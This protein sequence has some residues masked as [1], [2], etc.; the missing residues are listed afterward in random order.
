MTPTPSTTP[1]GTTPAGTT[2]AA[3]GRIHGPWILALALILVSLGWMIAEPA[4]LAGWLAASAF[5]S[6]LPL[7]ALVLVMMIRIIPG[8][9]RRELSGPGEAMMLLLPLMMLAAL[10]LLI[11]PG[12]VYPWVSGPERTGFRTLYLTP[13]F[14]ALRTVIF[15]AVVAGFAALLLLARRRP[16]AIPAGGLILVTLLHTM[17]AVD[18]LMSL[19]PGFHSSGF[20][21][22]VL[23]IQAASALAVAILI[24][25]RRG[26]G[27]ARPGI[28]GGLLLSALLLW[29]YFAFMQY[30]IS[31]SDDLPDSVLWYQH[32]AGGIWTV[33]IW[34]VAAL[35]FVPALLL[36]F[37]PVRHHRRWLTG[38]AIAVLAGRML[39]MAWL[40][41]P[42][43]AGRA[44]APSGAI[45]VVAGLSF[46][47]IGLLAGLV[48]PALLAH[49]ARLRA[50]RD[51]EGRP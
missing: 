30:F 14:F 23:S 49:A 11:M 28:L 43:T 4:V 20:G 39:E 25:L 18:W 51:A 13:W 32:R 22:Y 1:A 9:W 37:P 10:P 21:L 33:V 50:R 45:F 12:A 44:G 7:G 38:L 35:S 31:W 16:V 19:E 3:R 42:V 41:L 36:L 29:I 34:M 40:V 5:W 6:G 27:A 8:S 2:R 46:A 47:G 26:G 24:R 48:L 17:F 15:L